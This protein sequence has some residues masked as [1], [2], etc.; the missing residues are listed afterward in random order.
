MLEKITKYQSGEIIFVTDQYFEMSIKGRGRDKRASTGQIRTTASR[1]DQTT[2]KIF[3]KYLSVG[4]N[5][6][7]LLQFVLNEIKGILPPFE[8]KRLFFT[9]WNEGY[10]IEIIE[11]ELINQR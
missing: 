9:L 7:K 8:K 6:P 3:K 10:V 1:Q 11:R 2:P 5:K 4:A